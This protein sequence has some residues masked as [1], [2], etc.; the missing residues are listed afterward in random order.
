VSPRSAEVE[1][2][3]ARGKR[4]NVP[5]QQIVRGARNFFPDVF[6]GGMH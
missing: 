3:Q 1:E 2:A 6:F 4:T 5:A